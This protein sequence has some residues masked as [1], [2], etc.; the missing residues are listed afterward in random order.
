MFLR[1]R[2]MGSL[3]M[4]IV[5]ILILDIHDLC[6]LPADSAHVLIL[7]VAGSIISFVSLVMITLQRNSLVD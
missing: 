4:M 3:V 2:P 6:A 1:H 7:A 5:C